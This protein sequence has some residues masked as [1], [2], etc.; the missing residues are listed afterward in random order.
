MAITY[1]LDIAF[2]SAPLAAAPAWTDCT[3]YLRLEYGVSITRGGRPDELSTCQPGTLSLTL[4]NSSGAFTKG[5]AAS[6][7]FPNV[8]K[9]VRVRVTAIVGG[10]EYVRWD[11]HADDFRLGY[12]GGTTTASLVTLTATSRLKLIARRG[13]LR[14]FLG[15]EVLFDQP[16]VYLPLA[17]AAAATT[18]ENSASNPLGNGTIRNI[19]GGGTYTLGTATGPP[20]D[21]STALQLTP[22][23][24]TSGYFVEVPAPLFTYG[25]AF[26]VTLEGWLNSTQAISVFAVVLAGPK[27]NVLALTLDGAKKL[28]SFADFGTLAATSPGVVA[29]GTTR[30]VAVTLAADGTNHVLRIYINGVQ[31]NSASAANTSLAFGC[32]RVRVG[33]DGYNFA[34]SGVAAHVAFHPTALSAARIKAHYDAGW[35]GFAG[36]RSDQ[37]V[38]RIAAYV[39][40]SST[41]AA[42][43]TGVWIFDD[44]VFGLFDTTTIFGSSD[45]SLLEQGSSTIY[46]QNAGGQDAQAMFADVGTTENG[47]TLMTRDGLLTMQARTHRYNRPPVFSVSSTLLEPGLTWSEDDSHQVNLVTATTQDGVAQRARN[48]T[49]ITND[50]G[51]P[52]TDAVSLLTRDPLD[53][54]SNASWRVNR[55]GTPQTRASQM[56]IDLGTLDDMTAQQ[57]L[58]ADV[59]DVFQVTDLAAAWAPA[60][61][62]SLFIEDYSEQIGLGQHLITWATSNATGSQV[63]VFDHPVFGVFDVSTF[64][65]F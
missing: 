42:N 51:T 62:S 7:F 14:S 24:G 8:K 33:C 11:G 58:P 9:N 26:G 29:D 17:D 47:L 13:S 10:V 31:V 43:R 18:V 46:G 6:P 53:A 56:A 34:Y 1:R 21:G 32:D 55:F 52:V 45:V 61:T 39:G 27:N 41:V 38:G 16:L 3:G 64:F 20:A 59:G 44:P 54:Y 5:Y 48:Q 60:G 49:S 63:W 28:Q 40:L 35:T 15:E 22:A 2:G 37:R 50:T 25:T 36:E 4:D 30:H 65:A 57:I 19:G 23:S 12:D